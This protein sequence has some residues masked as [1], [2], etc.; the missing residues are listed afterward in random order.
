MKTQFKNP[1]KNFAPIFLMLMAMLVLG[2]GCNTSKPI[3]DPLAGWK[4]VVLSYDYEKFDKAIKSD[5]QDYIQKLPPDEKG[6]NI[7]SITFFEDGTGR[8]AVSIEKFVKG[9]NAS[10]HYAL[11][12]DKENKRINVIKYGYT[13]YQS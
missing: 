3:P 10:W 13:K 5:Y 11:I 1:I 2:F 8:H 4:Q 7:G 6:Y 9:E 12:Y